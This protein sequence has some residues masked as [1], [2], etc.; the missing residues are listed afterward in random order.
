M[1]EFLYVKV[2]SRFPVLLI[3][4]KSLTIIS[5]CEF[6]SAAASATAVPVSI[7]GPLSNHTQQPAAGSPPPPIAQ[8][9][10]IS[11]EDDDYSYDDDQVIN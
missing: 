2:D 9:N 8:A 1:S 3:R 6:Q 11:I 5:Q 4:R 7:R 10:V